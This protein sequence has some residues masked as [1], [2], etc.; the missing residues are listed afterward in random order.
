MLAGLAGALA[1]FGVKPAKAA[2]EVDPADWSGRII[3]AD[4]RK[5]EQMEATRAARAELKQLLV[6]TPQHSLGMHV[7]VL[8]P[9]GK[10]LRAKSID[11]RSGVATA[12]RYPDGG[13][14][15]R[16]ADGEPLVDAIAGCTVELLPFAPEWARRLLWELEIETTRYTGWR[17]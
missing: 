3:A 5:R 4:R 13:P 11:L 15:L 7:R 1:V 8:D 12:I 9:W 6:I 14:A 16:G 2:P 10:E 17:S